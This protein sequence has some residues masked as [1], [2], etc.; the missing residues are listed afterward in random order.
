M[1][2]VQKDVYS[3][4]DRFLAGQ[5]VAA[6]DRRQARN[7]GLEPAVTL[8]R[9]WNG[10]MDK[11]LAAPLLITLAYQ[12]V[13]TAAAENASPGNGPKYEFTMAPAAIEKLLRERPDGWF[14]D[15]DEMLLRALADAVEEGRR[16]QGPDPGKWRYGK[17]L[18]IPLNN[19]VIHGVPLVG[20]YF[21]I[22]PVA[23][24]GGGRTLKQ[25]TRAVSPSMRMN[26]DLA[27]WDRSTLNVLTGQSGQILSSYYRDQWPRHYEGRSFPMQFRRLDVKET[28][29]F[30]PD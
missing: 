3:G 25:T 12:Y 14:R 9:N 23:M 30:R 13:R 24:S 1:L 16:M 17:A 5:L 8:L 27:D 20:K 7:P 18:T 4:F 26:A 28:L 22:G 29:A 10:Q 19:P 15:Y 2:A 6:Y 21:D 11:D